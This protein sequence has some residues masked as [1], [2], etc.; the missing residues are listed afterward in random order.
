LAVCL[1][2]LCVAPRRSD[3]YC[4]LADVPDEGRVLLVATARSK[5]IVRLVAAYVTN[6]RQVRPSLNGADLKAMGLKPGPIYKKILDRL[7][8]ARLNGEVKTKAD[9][10]ELAKK[11]AKV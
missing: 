8:E 9:E 1:L 3:A 6:Q 10:L 5:D 7:H 4:V 11:L 2:A